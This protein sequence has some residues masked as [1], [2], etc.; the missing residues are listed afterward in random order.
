M[1][2]EWERQIYRAS[3]LDEFR[4]YQSGVMW[5]GE[6]E[7][8]T[9][10]FLHRMTGPE[11]E[12]D[13]HAAGTAVHAALECAVYG[14]LDDEMK[15]NGWDIIFDLDVAVS[16]PPVREVPLFREH[17]GIPLYGRCDAIDA[18]TVHDIKTTK[19]IDANT[20]I[21]SYQWRAYLWLSG[22]QKFVYDIFRVIRDEKAS[23]V[24]V[25]EYVSIPLTA[26]PGLSRDVESLLVEFDAAVKALGIRE[27]MQ[28]KREAAYMADPANLL[29]AG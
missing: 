12:T 28:K 16:L 27:I 10:E 1:R 6:T 2:P 8:T 18:W 14:P 19:A 20:Y 13:A 7:Y 29:A 17:N 22:R 25:K 15:V 4:L 26:Y 3:R 5:D 9:E 21:E 23:E 24:T 11:E